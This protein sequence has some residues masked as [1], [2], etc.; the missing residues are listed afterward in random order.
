MPAHDG[1]YDREMVTSGK[2]PASKT[3][4]YTVHIHD[5]SPQHKCYMP[6]WQRAGN[7]ENSQKAKPKGVQPETAVVP[8]TDVP[9][10]SLSSA[11]AEIYALSEASKDVARMLD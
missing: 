5:P 6:R 8:L 3:D 4:E 10:T 2:V 11:A 1:A 7:K 9:Q